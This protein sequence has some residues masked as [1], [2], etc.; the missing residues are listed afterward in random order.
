MSNFQKKGYVTHELIRLNNR[1][2]KSSVYR[3]GASRCGLL[4]A[5]SHLLGSLTVD[6]YVDVFHSVQHVRNNRPEAIDCLVGL[7]NC[8]RCSAHIGPLSPRMN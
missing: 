7:H 6:Q 4:C 2:S 8:S 5:A 3:D 1:Y